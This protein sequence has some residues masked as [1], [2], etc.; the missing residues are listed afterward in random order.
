MNEITLISYQELLDQLTNDDIS[1]HLLLGNG[2]NNSLGIKTSYS[3]IFSRM[4]KEYSGYQD[5]EKYLEDEDFDIEK[6]IGH[7]KSFIKLNGGVFLENYIERKVKLDFMKAT[8]EIVQESIKKIYKESNEKIYLLFKNFTNYFTLNYDPF[9]YL[10]LLKFKKEEDLNEGLNNIYK[11]IKEAKNNGTLKITVNDNEKIEDLRN[12]KKTQFE[13]IVKNYF[14]DED[15][16]SVDIKKACDKIW[17]EEKRNNQLSFNDGF[18]EE[19]FCENKLQNLYFLHGAFHLIKHKNQILKITAKQNK[20]FVNKLEEAINSD[21]KDII[22][23]LTNQSEEK[24]K[25]IEENTY[26]NKCFNALSEIYGSLV[27]L[28]SSLAENDQHI[29]AQINKS[30]ITKIYF[31]SCE[32]H[33]ERDY[34]RVNRLFNEKEVILFDYKTISYS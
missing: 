14:K 17:K 19:L 13:F 6:L 1:S 27:I 28:G 21:S 20:S 12:I 10:L 4:K 9:L 26:L 5:V 7:L 30:N 8:N 22:C 24:K 25:Q 16:K 15:W 11:K 32:A 2:F 33:K 23:I 18:N 29:F 34:Q 31:S 3:E